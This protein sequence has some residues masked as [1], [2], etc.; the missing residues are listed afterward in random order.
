M[1]ARLTSF[2]VL[3]VGSTS[4]AGDLCVRSPGTAARALYEAHR[5]FIF[6]GAPSPPLSE[7]FAQ[8]VRAN[9]D[10]Q[11]RTGDSG[12]IDWNYWTSAQD[13]EQSKTAKV[14]S[15]KANGREAQVM[16][17]YRFYPS[18]HERHQAKRSTVKLSRTREGCW[19]VEDVQ[20]GKR[21]V[22]SYLRPSQ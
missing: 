4:F 11:R 7:A 1:R 13:G 22:L 9:L 15:V 10:E 20:N 6:S 2:F 21:S 12:L 18:P 16:L 19:L 8:A 14:V 17:E 5:D 3:L